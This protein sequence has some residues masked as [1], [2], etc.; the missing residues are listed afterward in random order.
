MG[1]L[2]NNNSIY[3]PD[4]YIT[5]WEKVKKQAAKEELAPGEYICRRLKKLEGLEVK[6]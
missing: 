1:K 2:K 4:K 6:K 3:I 5:F